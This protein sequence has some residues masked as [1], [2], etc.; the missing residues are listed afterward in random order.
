MLRSKINH[1]IKI[2]FH[3]WF[4]S[5]LIFLFTA[6]ITNAE[7]KPAHE[8]KSAELES[9][10]SQIKDVQ[11]GL[12]AARDESDKLQDELRKNEIAAGKEALKLKGLEEQ[13]ILKHNKLD[14]LNNVMNRHEKALVTERNYLAQQIRA[15]YTTGRSDYLKLLLNQEDPAL[16]GR[17]LAYYDYYN[18]ARTNS[19]YSISEKVDLINQLHKAIQTETVALEE[20]KVRQLAR[21]E[22]IQAYRESRSAILVRLQDYITEQGLQLKSLQEHEQELAILLEKLDNYEDSIVFFE[23]I[24]PFNTL[25]GKLNWPIEGKLL[26]SFG[27]KR[28]GAS[29]KWQGIKISGEPGN[30]VRAVHT[31]KV[32]FADWFRNMGLLIILDHGD[33]YMSLYGNNQNLLKKAGDW[34]LAGET[35]AYVGDSGGQSNPGVYFE[36]R[37]RGEPLNPALWCR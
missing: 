27:S 23:D 4:T 33:D 25:Q 1:A 28:K 8:D 13:I 5:C 2:A 29:L 31:G 11:T 37:H 17:V 26:N 20:L 34:V 10:R 18:R 35:I 6:G 12:N 14:K 15:A 3:L 36:I 21:S 16:V 7:D 32:I 30:E 9:V 24:P 19:I 22:E